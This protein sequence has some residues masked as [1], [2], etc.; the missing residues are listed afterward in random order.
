M[1]FLEKVNES[2]ALTERWLLVVIVLIMVTLAFLQVV[3]R[4]VFAHGLLWG[5]TFL[6]QLVLWVGFIGASLATRENKHINIDL[7][8]RL[9]KGRAR[10]VSGMITELFAVIVSYFLANAAWNFVAE[11]RTFNSIAFASIP[12]WYFEIIIPIGFGLM[13]LRFFFSALQKGFQVFHPTEEHP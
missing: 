3:L 8:S 4:N 13:A 2:I 11:E 12:A 6:R 5:D 10:L 9:L 7:F 1:K